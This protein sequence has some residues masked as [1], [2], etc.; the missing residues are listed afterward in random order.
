VWHLVGLVAPLAVVC[1][2][3]LVVVRAC[4]VQSLDV[5]RSPL[6]TGVDFMEKTIELDD[7]GE[8]V[9]LMI[10]DTAGQEEFDSLTSRYYK[11][12][13]AAVLV[14]ST[15]DRDSFDALESWK[16]KVEDECGPIPMALVQNKIDLMHRAKMTRCDPGCGLLG[17][18]WAGGRTPLCWLGLNWLVITI[19]PLRL[20]LALAVSP[21][22][23]PV[24]PRTQ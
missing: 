7:F 21:P 8:T 11:G 23:P 4:A 2:A 9:R 13:G 5:V 15:E 20:P 24:S 17:C 16:R 22:P 1:L 6:F 19:L 3:A 10:W 18:R 14:F 12:A